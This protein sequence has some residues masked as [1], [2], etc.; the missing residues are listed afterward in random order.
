MTIRKSTAKK[1]EI[2]LTKRKNEAL[3]PGKGG[4]K[5]ENN[6]D[7]HKGYNEDEYD[8]KEITDARRRKAS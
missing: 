3:A 4:A 8:Q 1:R 6:D 2:K 5:K 7:L